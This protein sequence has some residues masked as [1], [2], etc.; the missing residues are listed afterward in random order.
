MDVLIT[1]FVS[2]IHSCTPRAESCFVRSMLSFHCVMSC[3][4]MFGFEVPLFSYRPHGY[5]E[6]TADM[7][8]I[9]SFADVLSVYEDEGDSFARNR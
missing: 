8:A 4:F 7:P 6:F 1:T 5:V 2:F 9:P 3:L